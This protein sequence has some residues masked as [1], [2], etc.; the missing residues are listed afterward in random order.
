MAC[1]EMPRSRNGI[2]SS[3]TSGKRTRASRATGQHS[4][5]RMH[6]R[7]SAIKSF[8]SRC[9]IHGRLLA[10]H[11]GTPRPISNWLNLTFIRDM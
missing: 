3:H 7:S 9:Y 8:I 11:G 1:S 5:K 4:E 2:E 10:W 6:Q